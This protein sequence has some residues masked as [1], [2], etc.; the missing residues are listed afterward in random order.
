MKYIYNK[1]RKLI[2]LHSSVIFIDKNKILLFL[3]NDD[4]TKTSKFIAETNKFYKD[5]LLVKEINNFHQKNLL[6]ILT[7]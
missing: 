5:V 2:S 6:H 7:Y 4:S 3:H 1:I